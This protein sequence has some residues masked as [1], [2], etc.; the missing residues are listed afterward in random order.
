MPT[1][2]VILDQLCRLGW[3]ISTH[4]VAHRFRLEDI[5][6]SGST[7]QLLRRVRDL[8]AMIAAQWADV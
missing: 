7:I 5:A 1:T 8:S 2:A 3:L 4:R 6:H